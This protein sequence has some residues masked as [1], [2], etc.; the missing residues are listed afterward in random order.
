MKNPI[1][2]IE[3]MRNIEISQLI[4]A[5]EYSA[6]ESLIRKLSITEISESYDR[7][8]NISKTGKS[9]LRDSHKKCLSTK[10]LMLSKELNI[11]LLNKKITIDK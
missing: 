1:N 5:E 11:R 4:L 3:F 8:R 9:F 7:C 2:K 6:A 10:M